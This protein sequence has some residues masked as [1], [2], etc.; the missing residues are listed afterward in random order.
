M[1]ECKPGSRDSTEFRVRI[2][3]SPHYN[4]GEDWGGA[5]RRVGWKTAGATSSVAL[6]TLGF[7]SCRR[8]LDGG[9]AGRQAAAGF[10]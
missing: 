3:W 6:D 8:A 7:L 1:A 9:V 10:R 5:I 4:P 2:P